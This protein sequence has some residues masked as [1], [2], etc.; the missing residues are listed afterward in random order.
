MMMAVMVNAFTH[1]HAIHANANTIRK[2]KRGHSHYAA[3]RRGDKDEFPHQN[4]L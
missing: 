2:R 4:L 1:R 3:R